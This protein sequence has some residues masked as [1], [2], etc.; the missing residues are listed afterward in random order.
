MVYVTLRGSDSLL[1]TMGGQVR[2]SKGKSI[3]A[4]H[5][6]M[7]QHHHLSSFP[8]LSSL[9]PPFLIAA[10][11]IA[12]LLFFSGTAALVSGDPNASQ[13][14][15]R[16]GSAAVLELPLLA[17]PLEPSSMSLFNCSAAPFVPVCIVCPTEAAVMRAWVARSASASFCFISIHFQPNAHPPLLPSSCFHSHFQAPSPHNL[18]ERQKNKPSAP[19]A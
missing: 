7:E 6:V 12:A 4:L 18:K 17:P 1:A 9:P 8:Q 13:K 15:F 10:V 19:S 16:S 2:F 5:P 11:P 14:S 3:A